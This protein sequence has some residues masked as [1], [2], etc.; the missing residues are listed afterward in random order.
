MDRV[1]VWF[2]DVTAGS[3]AG[4]DDWIEVAD[5]GQFNGTSLGK[6]DDLCGVYHYKQYRRNSSRMM[7]QR[8]AEMREKKLKVKL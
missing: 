3:L 2:S 7:G 4:A 6:S 5:I 8:Q 1:H